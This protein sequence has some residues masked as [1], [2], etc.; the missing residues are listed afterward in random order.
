MRVLNK[1]KNVYIHGKLF[2]VLFCLSHYFYTKG[3]R[4]RGIT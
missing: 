1:F 2:D 4:L 3:P